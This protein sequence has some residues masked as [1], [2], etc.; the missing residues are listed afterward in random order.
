MP[1]AHPAMPAT[2]ATVLEDYPPGTKAKLLAVR[3]LILDVAAK[4]DVE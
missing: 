4:M 1:I 3:R 2:V